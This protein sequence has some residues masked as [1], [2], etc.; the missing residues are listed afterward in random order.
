MKNNTDLDLDQIQQFKILK[1][2]R[3][4][5]R[6]RD[7]TLHE[8]PENKSLL[9]SV[10]RP[11][12]DPNNPVICCET[13]DSWERELRNRYLHVTTKGEASKETHNYTLHTF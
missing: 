7:I 4:E 13:R 3:S 9:Y 8:H 10:G 11:F 1:I 6:Q 5:W 2:V 12:L